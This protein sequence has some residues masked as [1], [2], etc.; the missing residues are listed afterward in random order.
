MNEN[1]PFNAH[2]IADV[3]TKQATSLD[4]RAIDYIKQVYAMLAASIIV[5][6][7]AGHVGMTLPF[8]REHPF[9]MMLFMFGAIFLAYKIQNA[10][11]LFLFTG[12]SGLAV[13]PII[14]AFVGAGL[15]HLVGQAAFMTGAAF[16]G[17]SFYAMTTRKDLSM[18]GGIMFAG[19]IVLIVGS[20]LNLFF[21]STAVAFAL[22]AC[23]SVIFCGFILYET[24]QLKANP[25]AVAPSV[26]ALSMFLNILNLF[27]MLLQ[28]LGIMG[29]DD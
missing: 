19:L 22:S 23:G 6:V 8:A 11:T 3:D 13:G 1:S 28:L 5:A 26:A 25:G 16:V 2:E 4:S 27:L 29:S 9:I 17:L 7:A 20:L 24:Q 10:G 15:S 21:H 18:L 14:A 12:I